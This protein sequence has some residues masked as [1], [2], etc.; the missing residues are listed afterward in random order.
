MLRST[1]STIGSLSQYSSHATTA[2][3][4]AKFVSQQSAYEPFG[5]AV[6]NGTGYVLDGDAYTGYATDVIAW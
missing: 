6:T 5:G 1:L 2:L 4:R 3:Y